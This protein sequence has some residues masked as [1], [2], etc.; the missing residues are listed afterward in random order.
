[1]VHFVFGTG[2][3]ATPYLQGGFGQANL[4]LQL[5]HQQFGFELFARNLTNK[6]AQEATGDPT[7]GGYAYML[8][9]RELGV[10][11]RYSFDEPL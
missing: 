8:R 9:P 6:R 1:D 3:A 11:V 5:Q 7:Q 4:R 2:A 10:E